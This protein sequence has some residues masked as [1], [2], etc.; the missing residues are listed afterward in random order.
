M[1]LN[2]S[3]FVLEIINFLVLVWILKRFLYRPVLAALKQRQDRIEQKLDEAAKL[4]AEGSD[5]ER[6]YRGRMEDWDREKQQ[7]RDAL[8]QEL[9]AER[10]RKLARLQ[11][12]LAH[13]KEKAAIVEQR[14]QTEAQQQYQRN[15]HK[16]GARFAASLLSSV[17]GPE[18]ELRLF[19]LLLSS[20]A[21]LDQEHRDKLRDNCRLADN[22]ITV[23]SAFSLSSSQHK[24]LSEKLSLLCEQPVQ[25][26]YRVDPA[27]IAGLRL[28][29]G[30]WV[31][32]LNLQDELKGF[33]DLSHEQTTS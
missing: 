16:Q 26:E 12:E 23:T 5:L 13:E 17:A 21:Q 10:V 1:E 24:Q 32:H 22:N 30:A 25:F 18:L 15:A 3:T 29:V 6:Q 28:T 14:H 7:A 2:W 19:E 31:L 27:L 33:A 11:Q 9:E 20:F 8:H 4:K